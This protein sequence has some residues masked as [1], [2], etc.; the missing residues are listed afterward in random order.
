VR[1]TLKKSSA[2]QVQANQLGGQLKVTLVSLLSN[3]GRG[4]AYPD[5]NWAH[6][7]RVRL[8]RAG[9]TPELSDLSLRGM[10]FRMKYGAGMA[11]RLE[12]DQGRG[13]TAL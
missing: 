4:R 3:G 10:R 1:E 8:F 11:G 13:G 9:T 5:Q 12:S 7:T 6:W 2:S